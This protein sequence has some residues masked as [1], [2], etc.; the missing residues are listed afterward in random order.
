MTR[1]KQMMLKECP[2]DEATIARL[3]QINAEFYRTTAAEFDRTRGQAWPGWA[4]LL[5]YLPDE[6][7]SLSVFDVGCGNGRFGVFMA[8]QRTG[9]IAYHGLDNNRALL[10]AAAGAL[11]DYAHVTVT[12]ATHDIIKTPLPA[13]HYDVVVLF[14]VIHHIPGAAKRLQLMRDL[15][16]CVAKGGILAFAAWRFYDYERFRRRIVDW[17]DDIQVEA[18]DYLLDWR[19]GERALR[20]CHFV[21]DDEHGQLVAVTGLHLIADYRADSATGDA[22]RYSILRA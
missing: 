15:A 2:L 5:P 17:P 6:A 22:N 14:G 12:L 7:Q 3:N 20:Y 1:V 19:Q 11:A 9:T 10:A 16:A 4:R 8:E 13:S 21:D 18:H